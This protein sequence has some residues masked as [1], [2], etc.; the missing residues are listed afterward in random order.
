MSL[1]PIPVE[2][3]FSVYGLDPSF[4]GPRW[5]NVWKWWQRPGERLWQVS[6]GHG[7]PDGNHLIV[8][9]DAKRPQE[10]VAGGKPGMQFVGPT[11]VGSVAL[12]SLVDAIPLAYPHRP[13]N[14]PSTEVSQALAE[15]SQ[16]A[17]NIGEPAWLPSDKPIVVAGEPV[18][19]WIRE[20]GVVCVAVADVQDVAIGIVACGIP[21]TDLALERINETLERY[22]PLPAE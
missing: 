12:A 17:G 14:E 3:D 2:P 5:L 15:V 1:D 4:T 13:P 10:E 7:D 20:I 21:L 9:T 18:A 19:F 22:Q 16:L 6:L 11:D 8:T